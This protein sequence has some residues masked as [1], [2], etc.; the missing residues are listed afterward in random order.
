MVYNYVILA[1][2]MTPTSVSL[3]NCN[4]YWEFFVG[5]DLWQTH[6]E[7]YYLD[8][9]IRSTKTV[10]A[11]LC[12]P[13]IA[14]RDLKLHLGYC[15]YGIY[16]AWYMMGLCLVWQIASSRCKYFI[17]IDNV[18]LDFG[19][20]CTGRFQ[21]HTATHPIF[22][23]GNLSMTLFCNWVGTHAMPIVFHNRDNGSIYSTI[24]AVTWNCIC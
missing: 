8:I 21:G 7:F 15:N 19:G 1:T 24:D 11:L 3:V 22:I 17:C 6:G 16:C 12:I 13:C 18:P 9:N 10:L 4:F 14:F 23:L 2:Y 5:P 20:H